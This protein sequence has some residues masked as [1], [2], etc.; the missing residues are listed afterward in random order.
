MPDEIVQQTTLRDTLTAN[1]EAAEAG[2]LETPEQA[3]ARDEGGRFVRQEKVETRPVEETPKVEAQPQAQA[4][5]APAAQRPI[6]TWRKEYLPLWDKLSQGQP[7]SAEEAKK[8]ADY[9]VQRENEYKTG[10]STYKAEA[11]QAREL[12]EA[13]APFMQELQAHNLKPTDW[14]KQVGQVHQLLVRG[15]P[16]QKLEVFQALAQRYGVPLAAVQQQAQGGVPPLVTNL[17][18][19]IAEQKRELEAVKGQVSSVTGWKQ[20]LE[21]QSLEGEIQK[22]AA[23]A[24]TYPHFEAVRES[25]AQ[26]LEQ[27]AA[28]DLPTAYK[29]AVRLDDSLMDEELNQRLAAKQSERTNTAAQARARAVSPKSATPRGQVTTSGAKDRR[30]VLS[31]QFD[32]HDGGRV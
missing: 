10:V 21:T 7:L 25:M 20:Q 3:R 8:L 13:V 27:G 11:V 28:R 9:S 24:T 30:S 1:L 16:Q 6:T 2:I 12:Q 26:L 23:D 15:N 4:Q 18:G 5:P 32:A 29:L 14:I 19:I 22:M 17:M 31:E